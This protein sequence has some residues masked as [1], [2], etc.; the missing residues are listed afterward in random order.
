M[1]WDFSSFSA[2][3]FNLR[4][5]GLSPGLGVLPHFSDSFSSIYRRFAKASP[6]S[7]VITRDMYVIETVRRAQV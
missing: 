2:D 5:F 3:V 6:H 7:L 4:S 1:R